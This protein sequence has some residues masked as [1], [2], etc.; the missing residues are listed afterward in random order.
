[1]A[2]EKCIPRIIRVRLNSQKYHSSDPEELQTIPLGDAFYA[3]EEL[4]EEDQE[5]FFDDYPWLQ[6]KIFQEAW[7]KLGGIRNKMA[8]SGLLID[9]GVLEDNYA[10]FSRFLQFMPQIIELKQKLMPANYAEPVSNNTN[11]Y[12]VTTNNHDRQS[13]IE[14]ACQM[15]DTDV[16]YPGFDPESEII[17]RK[18]KFVLVDSEGHDMSEECDEIMPIN[19]N[20]P[21]MPYVFR[22][23]GLLSW[24]LMEV[25]GNVLCDCVI[26]RYREGNGGTFWFEVDGLL[27]LWNIDYYLEPI[28]ENI[29]MPA[30]PYEP[31]LFTLDGE[32]GYVRY[33]DFSFV[34]LSEFEQMSKDEKEEVSSDFISEEL[35]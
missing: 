17:E 5:G 25:N 26:D 20:D 15:D 9:N 33:D 18:G 7:R 4:L 29:E 14:A 16:C 34:P 19:D 24:G 1:M 21:Y 8:H 2:K 22:K 12:W 27:G 13:V 28:Y 11:S 30:T 32:Q 31:L 6:D 10:Y 3:L 35:Y 23:N